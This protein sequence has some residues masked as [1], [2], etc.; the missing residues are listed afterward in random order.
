MQYLTKYTDEFVEKVRNGATAEELGLTK[1]QFE[2]IVRY[3]IRGIRN[4]AK[5]P[6]QST[7]E[8]GRHSWHSKP[9]GSER[10]DKDGYIL[11]K[12]AY[13][14]VERRKHF[15]EWE[16]HNPPIDT[17]TECLIFLDGDKTNCNID[18]L[19][20]IKRKYMGCMNNFIKDKQL[21]PEERRT[22]C[23]IAE[24][25]C[26]MKE[27]RKEHKPI[28]KQNKLDKTQE[29]HLQVMSLYSAGKTNKEIAEIVGYT[30]RT[31][32]TYISHFH[33]LGKIGYKYDKNKR[34]S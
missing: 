29:R 25:Y 9:I 17:K 21:T 8:T 13:P 24:L 1:N 14:R 5:N 22:M 32:S 11:V 4:Y 34:K 30:K 16:K 10:F 20:K 19:F 3:R 18:N 23:L 12:V 28:K 33:E 27:K 15:I 31:I 6:R 2:H 26:K 7:G